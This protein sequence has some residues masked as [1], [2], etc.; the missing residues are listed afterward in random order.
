[1]EQVRVLIVDEHPALRKGLRELLYE[2]PGI[3]RVE[4]AS[5]LVEALEAVDRAVS[6]H[7]LGR[8]R[9]E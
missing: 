4:E 5:S 6:R 8:S 9:A 2:T 7:A 3:G 1:M